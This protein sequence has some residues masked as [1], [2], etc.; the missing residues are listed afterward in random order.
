RKFGHRKTRADCR[1]FRLHCIHP[2]KTFGCHTILL[3]T[4]ER[5][6]ASDILWQNRSKRMRRYDNCRDFGELSGWRSKDS[7]L[8]MASPPA[9]P[10]LRWN[11]L[12]GLRGQGCG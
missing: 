11:C 7:E 1:L 3:A 4:R 9:R 12:L 5:K 2:Y 10:D 6:Y 8:T